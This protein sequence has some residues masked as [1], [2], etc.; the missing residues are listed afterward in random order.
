MTWQSPVG[1]GYFDLYE[2]GS[3]LGC[4]RGDPP[5]VVHEAPGGSVLR[6]SS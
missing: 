6:G 2:E 4:S 3:Y 1:F 5:F